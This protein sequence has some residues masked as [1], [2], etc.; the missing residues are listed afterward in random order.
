MSCGVGRRR[1]ADPMWLWLLCRPGG[2]SSNLTTSLGI[3]ICCRYGPKKTKDRGGKKKEFPIRPTWLDIASH[4]SLA[5]PISP[6][7]Q[8]TFQ[9]HALS[10]V[11]QRAAFSHGW[12]LAHT[13]PSA[14][15]D[16]C[17][18]KVRSQLSASLAPGAA[19]SFHFI[20]TAC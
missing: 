7:A 16:L 3:S 10:P 17:P 5:S 2:C 6:R 8:P 11:T 9:P 13:V 15:I 18:D 14:Y 20:L 4:E 19:P 1:S 12:T